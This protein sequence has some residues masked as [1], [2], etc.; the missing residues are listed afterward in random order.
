MIEFLK[1]DANLQ[2]VVERVNKLIEIKNKEIEA[3]FERLKAKSNYLEAQ[4]KQKEK[5][6]E[7][8]M[9]TPNYW[10]IHL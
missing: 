3:E 8:I 5:I 4:L 6:E 10:R 7:L 9:T 2:D 1:E